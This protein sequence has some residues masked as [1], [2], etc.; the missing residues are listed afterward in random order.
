MAA[1]SGLDHEGERVSHEREHGYLATP[2]LPHDHVPHR[3]QPVQLA[4]IDAFPKR[5]DETA[6]EA[7]V[8][9]QRWPNVEEQS[10][11]FERQ[12]ALVRSG[13]RRRGERVGGRGS[14]ERHRGRECGVVPAGVVPHIVARELLHCHRIVGRRW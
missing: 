13:G 1:P 10:R 3:G 8:R 4:Q 7:D 6:P 9:P 2:C 12:P 5:E 14:D 11:A